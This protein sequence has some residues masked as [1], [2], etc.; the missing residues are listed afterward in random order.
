VAS[1]LVVFA[2]LNQ[3]ALSKRALYRDGAYVEMLRTPL[4]LSSTGCTF[5]V[6]C[7]E[8]GVPVLLQSREQWSIAPGGVFEETEETAKAQRRVFSEDELER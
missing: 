4:S 8:E 5:A 3:V 7:R 2:S 6:R 1:R